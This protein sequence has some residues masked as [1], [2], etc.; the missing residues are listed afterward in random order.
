[1]SE[2]DVEGLAK[3]REPFPPNQIG[4]LPK[5]GI[6]LDFLGHGYLTA[7]FLDVD[8]LWTWEPFA[9]GDNGLPLLDEH[10]GLWIRL[11]LC[12]VTRIGYGDA[13]GKKGPNA[14]K[15]AIGDA[16]RNAGMRF[17]AALDLWCKGDPDAPAPPD[18]A[19]AE[20]NALLHE[21]G[22][23]CAALTLDEKTVAAQFYGKY[24]VTA[25]NAKPQQLREFIDDLMENGAPA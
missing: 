2:P 11:T 15:E 9:V 22:D 3:L 13:G 16:L 18:P 8:P 1:M 21:L 24:K 19:V 23:A 25:R 10:G 17:G 4:K 14:V 5:G 6:T 20:R 7:R 12:G